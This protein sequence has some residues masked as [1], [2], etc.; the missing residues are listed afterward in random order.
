MRCLPL[1]LSLLLVACPSEDGEPTPAPL[2]RPDPS[3]LDLISPER[4][5][6]AVDFLADDAL[7]GRIPDSPGHD[8]ARARLVDELTAIGLE[9]LGTD[10]FEYEYEHDGEGSRGR[11]YLDEAGVVQESTATIGR[12]LVGLLPGSDPVRAAEYVVVSAH[13]DHLGVT[14]DGDVYN[15]AF[16]DAAGIAAV[17]EIARALSAAPPPRSVV[18]L[19]TDD[20]ESGLRGARA[21]STAP[22]VPLDDIVAVLS[23]DP[24]G[25]ALLPDYS[26]TVVI[27]GERSGAFDAVLREAAAW[28]EQPVVFIQRELVRVFHSDQDAFY[29]ATP[30][31]PGAWLVNPGM[32]FY[33]QT[34][35]TA[36]TIDYAV[37]ERTT[38][39]TAEAAFAVASDETRYAWD[40]PRDIGTQAMIGAQ[41]LIAGVLGSKELTT[42]ERTEAEGYYWSLQG[43][44]EAEDP[45]EL[46][47]VDAF[48]GGA[49]FF[50]L[51]DLPANHPGPIPPPF[52]G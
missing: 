40:G 51:F 45:N 14:E 19:L 36:E 10:G 48:I 37:L 4:M 16:D 22:T 38:R 47:N 15:G 21:W 8:L 18:F 25:R 24:V 42:D 27:G 50:L 2:P 30:P 12:D 3:A 6:E 23:V 28:S 44:I 33:H 49:L 13:Y 26:P 5:R 17:L 52:P 35:D 20:E 7:G 46:G 9:P 39:W 43:A 32:A 34:T 11:W 31:V 41:D 29:E 1:A